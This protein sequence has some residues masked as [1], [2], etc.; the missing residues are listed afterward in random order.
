MERWAFRLPPCRPLQAGDGRVRSPTAAADAAKGKF[1]SSCR[2]RDAGR[3]YPA[4]IQGVETT[5]PVFFRITVMA[6]IAAAL[7]MPEG[8][9]FA[10]LGQATP[11]EIG[12]QD[13]ATPVMDDVVW[14]HS[15]VFWI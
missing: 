3:P 2:F 5:M 10:G 12:L 13:S 15:F 6:V 8:A 7:L 11:W 4:A 1:A 14:L 9:A